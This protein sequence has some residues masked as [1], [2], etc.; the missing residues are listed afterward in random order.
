[1]HGANSFPK[2]SPSLS[3]ISLLLALLSL[4]SCSRL[5][6]AV[7]WADT[8]IV[9]AV[10]SRFDLNSEQKKEFTKEVYQSIQLLKKEKFPAWAKRFDK[11]AD[12]IEKEKISEATSVDMWDWVQSE[13]RDLAK[14][15]DAPMMK[16][17]DK[18]DEKNF[19]TNKKMSLK[20]I[21]ELRKKQQTKDAQFEDQKKKILRWIE[22]WHDSPTDAQ[23]KKLDAFI[24][25]S[26]FPI[27]ASWSHREAQII[28]FYDLRKDKPALRAWVK[29]TLYNPESLR[30]P[31]Y[32]A[33]IN[34]WIK[35][36]RIYI[37]EFHQSLSDKQLKF[38]V[39]ELRKRAGELRE[40][41]VSAN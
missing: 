4:S 29:E 31:E 14:Y 15:A 20:E 13:F 11:W 2:S 5:S 9:E 25:Q 40:L 24:K 17:I 26:P 8:L 39:K 28:K 19:E 36:L 23:D 41:A 35:N 27:E 6:I 21:D 7:R 33:A 12:A 37:R 30:P 34:E 22:F 10:D 3:V 38:L 1:M 18:I 32:Q 16:L